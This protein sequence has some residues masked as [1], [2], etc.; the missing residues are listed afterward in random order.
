MVESLQNL[1]LEVVPT[2]L[3]ISYGL[4][5]VLGIK[6]RIVND[7]VSCSLQPIPCLFLRMA[8]DIG[9]TF[10]YWF[11]E[12]L[13]QK[14]RRLPLN[15]A[16]FVGDKQN[17]D[18]RSRSLNVFAMRVDVNVVIVLV[19]TIV[20]KL[21]NGIYYNEKA[22]SNLLNQKHSKEWT[23]EDWDFL[24]RMELEYAFAVNA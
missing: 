17:Y 4:T 13:K 24:K 1:L 12:F 18:D 11:K 23:V 22:T 7:L 20:N 21:C 19:Y 15:Q 9:D 2:Q 5:H 3:I 14:I 10:F 8:T 6:N 16:I